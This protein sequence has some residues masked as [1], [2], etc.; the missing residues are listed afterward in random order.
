[1]SLISYHRRLLIFFAVVLIGVILSFAG[2]HTLG[3]IFIVC[4]LFS[5]AI[6]AAGDACVSVV[7]KRRR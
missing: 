4:A 5:G 2:L 7:E 6:H 1:M 3:A